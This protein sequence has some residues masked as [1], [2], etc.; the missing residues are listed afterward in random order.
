MTTLFPGSTMF[1]VT[2]NNPSWGNLVPRVSDLIMQAERLLADSLGQGWGVRRFDEPVRGSGTLQPDFYELVSERSSLLHPH[3][4]PLP[5]GLVRAVSQ[6]GGRRRGAGS[7]R[8]LFLPHAHGGQ[9]LP[10]EAAAGTGRQ[11]LPR[12]AEQ[13]RRNVRDR[14]GNCLALGVG[15]YLTFDIQQ[16]ILVHRTSRHVRTLGEGARPWPSNAR[17]GR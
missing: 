17:R 10:V 8:E 1:P 11:T 3:G 14:V 13:S 12:E 9:E 4:Q 6:C 2:G 7:T 15:N 16:R 5:Q